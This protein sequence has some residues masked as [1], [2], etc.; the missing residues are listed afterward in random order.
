MELQ[1]LMLFFLIRSYAIT[2]KI[3]NTCVS[4]ERA[5]IVAYILISLKLLL[6]YLGLHLALGLQALEILLT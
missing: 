3:I 6:Q 2:G 5:I 1:L 4:L